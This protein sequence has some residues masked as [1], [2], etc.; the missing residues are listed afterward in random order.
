MSTILSPRLVEREAPAPPARSPGEAVAR[1]HGYRLG[2][3]ARSIATAAFAML[4][5]G[6]EPLAEWADALPVGPLADRAVAATAAWQ[7]AMAATG[8]ARFGQ[9]CEA[10]LVALR[11]SR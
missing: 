9:A 5:L 1:A 11:G 7:D 3:V 2:P 4:L 8:L 10:L 6:A